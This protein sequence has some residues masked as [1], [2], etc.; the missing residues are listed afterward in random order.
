LFPKGF[1]LNNNS[2]KITPTDH[3]STFVEILGVE[4]KKHSGGKYQNVLLII[5]ITLFLMKLVQF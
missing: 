1:T 2:N 3:I 4:S 5:K